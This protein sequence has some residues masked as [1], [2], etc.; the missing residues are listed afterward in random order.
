MLQEQAAELEL[1]ELGG[2][3][4]GKYSRERYAQMRAALLQAHEDFVQ[5]SESEN[6]VIA[7]I[8]DG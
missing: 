4:G 1:E 2:G 5:S 3:G 8:Y 6:Q 7:I